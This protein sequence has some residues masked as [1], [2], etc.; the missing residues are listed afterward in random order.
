MDAPAL[1]IFAGDRQAAIALPVRGVRWVL[2]WFAALAVTAAAATILVAFGY[3]LS[4]ERA[5]VRAAAAGIREATC[6]RATSRSVA[7]TVRRELADVWELDRATNISVTSAGARVAICLSVPL[8]DVLPRWVPTG[9]WTRG[10]EIAVRR[11]GPVAG[12]LAAR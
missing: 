8:D 5:L 7:A 3:Q 9:R 4:A 10:A 6:P 2:R 11:S 1:Q 12:P